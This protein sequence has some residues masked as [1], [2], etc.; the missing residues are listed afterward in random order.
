MRV[1]HNKESDGYGG[2]SDGNKGVM[3]QRGQWQS[4]QERWQ[5]G[6]QASNSNGVNVSNGDGNKAGR[7]QR[8]QVQG[9]H[10][11]WQWQ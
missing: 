6:W 10:G 5:Q 3:Q 1:A 8:G 4:R 2:K 7:Q 9:Q 11:Q